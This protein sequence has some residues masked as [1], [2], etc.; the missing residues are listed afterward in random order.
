VKRREQGRYVVIRVGVRLVDCKRMIIT[1]LTHLKFIN[2]ILPWQQQ[3]AN[4]RIPRSIIPHF[5]RGKYIIEGQTLAKNVNMKTSIKFEFGTIREKKKIRIRGK[6]IK[7]IHFNDCAK[8][9][10]AIFQ[11]VPYC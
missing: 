5:L 10:C 4:N 11:R 2:N 7:Y 9:L 3:R 1:T 6:S 8:T